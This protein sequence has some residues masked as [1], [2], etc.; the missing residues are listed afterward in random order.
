VSCLG[1]ITPPSRHA[2]HASVARPNLA[3]QRVTLPLHMRGYL[4]GAAS[5][6]LGRAVREELF[7]DEKEDDVV[8]L[9]SPDVLHQV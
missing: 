2:S 9:H 8:R 3:V 4:R 6:V 1:L 7:M 5:V